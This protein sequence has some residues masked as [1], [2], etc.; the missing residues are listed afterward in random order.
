M[1]R[2]ATVI[3]WKTVDRLLKAGCTGVQIA[4]RLGIHPE[5]LYDNCKRDHKTDFSAYSA[6]KKADGETLLLEQQ[7]N[8]A[9]KGNL[10]MLIWLGKQRLGQKDKHEHGGDEDGAP[11][12][13]TLNLGGPA[14]AD[15]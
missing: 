3:D 4:A 10:G 11:I 7:M 1:A 13:V 15:G 6:E 12:K 8:L 9:M 2:S 5:T 14:H